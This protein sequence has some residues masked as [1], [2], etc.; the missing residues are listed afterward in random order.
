MYIFDMYEHY[1]ERSVS[2]LGHLFNRQYNAL[3]KEIDGM[4]DKQRRMRE[5]RD[6]SIFTDIT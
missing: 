4:R 3:K 5:E 6:V 2:L 1:K